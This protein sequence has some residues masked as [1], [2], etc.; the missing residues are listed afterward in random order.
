MNSTIWQNDRWL[1]DRTNYVNIHCL[2]YSHQPGEVG[3]GG[4]WFGKPLLLF[5]IIIRFKDTTWGMTD[6]TERI[7]DFVTNQLLRAYLTSVPEPTIAG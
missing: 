1:F 7:L 3:D 4:P 5:R 6:T 2:R